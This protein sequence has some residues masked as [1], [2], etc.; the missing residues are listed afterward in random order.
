[1]KKQY[2]QGETY[3]D[4]MKLC[5]GGQCELRTAKKHLIGT[6]S[7]KLF[8]ACIS[9]SE[10]RQLNEMSSDAVSEPQTR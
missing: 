10:Q 6:P 1:M 3:W 5:L 2:P 4:Q 7:R 9:R 8:S